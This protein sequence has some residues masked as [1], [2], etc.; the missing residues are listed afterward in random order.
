METITEYLTLNPDTLEE[1]ANGVP[2]TRKRIG[3]AVILSA[4]QAEIDAQQITIDKE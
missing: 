4:G 3:N 2:Y 1:D